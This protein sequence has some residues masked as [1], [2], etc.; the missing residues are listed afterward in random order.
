MSMRFTD[1]E[2]WKGRKFRRASKECKLLTIYLRDVSDSAGFYA[3]DVEHICYETGL[4]EEDVRKAVGELIWPVIGVSK[5][6]VRGIQGPVGGPLTGVDIGAMQGAGDG[7]VEEITD[8]GWKYISRGL[9]MIWLVDYIQFQQRKSVL[10]PSNWAH[11]EILRNIEKNLDIFPEGEKWLKGAFKGQGVPHSRVEY[12]KVLSR[13]NTKSTN[14]DTT[15]TVPKRGPGRPPKKKAQ[16]ETIM[17]RNAPGADEN[18]TARGM[19]ARALHEVIKQC[20]ELRS[21]KFDQLY[22]LMRTFPQADYDEAITQAI[23]KSQE[24]DGIDKPFSW[25]RYFIASSDAENGGS[26]GKLYLQGL[27]KKRVGNHPDYPWWQSTEDPEKYKNVGTGL[28]PP[29]TEYTEQCAQCF[30][31]FTNGNDAQPDDGHTCDPS[32]PANKVPPEKGDH[33]VITK[34]EDDND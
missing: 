9:A 14:T 28:V 32:N 8:E 3:F 15:V 19:K 34:K 30:Y 27:E 24:R 31:W 33:L 17:G 20:S 4:S 21:L 7:A 16:H 6:L 13:D 1:T 29:D 22:D 5:V 12:S 11:K 23:A 26:Q 2:K 10:N 25:V 18:S